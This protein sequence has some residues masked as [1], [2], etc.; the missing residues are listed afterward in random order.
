MTSRLTVCVASL[1]L[2]TAVLADDSNTDTSLS[3]KDVQRFTTAISEIKQYYVKPVS[4][5]ALFDAAIRG[6][7]ESL[8]PHSSYLNPDELKELHQSTSGEFSGLGL[9]VMPDKG[10]VK[11]ISPIDD[12]PASRAG[13]KAGDYIIRI[14]NTPVKGL[15]L[16]DAV[17][18]MRGTAGS[19]ITLEIFREGTEK[20]LKLELIREK[21]MAHSVKSRIIDGHYGYARISQFQAATAEDLEK[22]II[23][24]QRQTNNKLAGLVL[25]LRNN[26]GGL[27]DSAIQVSDLFL[28]TRKD[29]KKAKIVYTKGRLPGSD[30]EALVKEGDILKGAPMVILIN[31]GSASASEIVTG[32][33][34]DDRRALIVGT[35][36]FGKGSVQT[37]LPLDADHG[38]KLTTALYYTPSGTSIQA[39]GIDP[40]IEVKEMTL[41]EKDAPKAD[42]LD[43]TEA[44][45]SNH[46]AN[47]NKPSDNQKDS[48]KPGETK[49]SDSSKNEKTAANSMYNKDKPD[50]SKLMY[51]DYQLFEAVNILKGLALNK[52]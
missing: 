20:P 6:M 30:F 29:G 13:I 28:D 52:R 36:S 18:K 35:R 15:S 41:T 16:G 25:D 40:D 39:K 7:V 49:K 11:V 45:L 26:P 5:Q 46:L 23:N 14:D 38:I 32:A 8:D 34:K 12:S 1:M 3:A 31:G 17:K 47:G 48:A 50:D 37:V 10:L 4:D 51:T 9:E 21:I 44:D 42:L 19:K 27:L 22:A 33:L 24:M 2:G 43:M